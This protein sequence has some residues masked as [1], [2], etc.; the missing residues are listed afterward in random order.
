MSKKEPSNFKE[1][2]VPSGEDQFI[3]GFSDAEH[4]YKSFNNRKDL[5]ISFIKSKPFNEL[6]HKQYLQGFYTFLSG[7]G[8]S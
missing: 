5:A 4:L 2:L 1:K 8:V 6:F 3:F 7:K